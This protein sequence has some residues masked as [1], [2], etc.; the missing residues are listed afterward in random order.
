MF[1]RSTLSSLSVILLS[2][3]LCRGDA[4]THTLARVSHR[5]APVD[6]RDVPVMMAQAAAAGERSRPLSQGDQECEQC[7]AQNGMVEDLNPAAL[8]VGIDFDCEPD[9]SVTFT[10]I[11]GTTT[12]TTR[13]PP[14]P[15]TTTTT[16]TTTPAPT[17]RPCT[18]GNPL[19]GTNDP[20]S[21]CQ[22]NLERIRI[23]EA[24]RLIES[25]KRKLKKVV[26]VILDSGVNMKHPDLAKQFW[27]DPTTG[28]IGYNFVDNNTDV[29]DKNGHGTF[30]AGIAGAETNNSIGVAGAA[31]VELMIVKWFDKELWLSVLVRAFDYVLRQGATVSSHSYTFGRGSQIFKSVIA[32]VSA[33]GHIVIAGA[34][35]DAQ[36]LDQNPVYPCSIARAIPS[37]LCVAASTSTSKATTITYWSNVGAA[38]QIA[39]PGVDIYSTDRSGSYSS[40]SGTSAS[41][42]Q[43]AA[44]A[45]MM[46]ALGLQG[47]DITA[48]ITRSRTAGLSNQFNVPD[49]GELDALNAVKL[50]LGQPTSPREPPRLLQQV[51]VVSR[52]DASDRSTYISARW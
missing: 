49:V 30:C 52:C 42:P 31:N 44:V 9:Y 45:A 35:N 16:P 19:L 26:L 1:M 12:T 3:A 6:I 28:S 14:P 17:P 11:S 4:P 51:R 18:G 27:R 41:T 29:T 23:W 39:A 15:R 7:L 22:S 5:G 20:V 43:V 40:A 8:E 50:A 46:A 32:K 2:T 21:S 25:S 33:A 24:W 10:P 48:A 47:Q 37:M 34:G 36:S 38:T 13:R